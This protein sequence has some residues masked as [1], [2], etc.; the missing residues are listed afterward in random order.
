M[1]NLIILEKN[2]PK[3]TAERLAILETK[4]D[5]I[6]QNAI[7][8]KHELRELQINITEQL[9]EMRTESTEQH[10]VL[11]S[12]VDSIEKT[13]SRW[14][15]VVTGAAAV[16]AFVLGQSDTASKLLGMLF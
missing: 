13:Q 7:Q 4:V 1:M 12:K 3:T 16:V 5:A 10:N 11:A 6:E 14:R 15:Y 2:V 9:K 8:I